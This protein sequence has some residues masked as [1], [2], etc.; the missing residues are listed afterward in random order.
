MFRFLD[1]WGGLSF[2]IH[3]AYQFSPG[4][5]SKLFFIFNSPLCL[6]YHCPCEVV[7]SF[8]PVARMFLHH[9]FPRSE[10]DKLALGDKASA[11]RDWSWRQV[12]KVFP[13]SI[14]L[15]V[16]LPRLF[17]LAHL[18][19]PQQSR[20]LLDMWSGPAAPVSVPGFAGSLGQGCWA[21]HLPPHLPDRPLLEGSRGLPPLG[22]AL[23][24]LSSCPA[25]AWCRAPA[26]VLWLSWGS[27]CILLHL[28]TVPQH[29]PAATVP[30]AGLEGSAFL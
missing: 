24:R 11:S 5:P 1:F 16:I 28:H 8:P 15:P 13:L 29:S 2:S 23:W 27:P 7:V 22:R 12:T 25:P 6:A 4:S 26:S 10:C 21:W 19:S 20:D 14:L 3:P 18:A 9:S 30:G 17:C